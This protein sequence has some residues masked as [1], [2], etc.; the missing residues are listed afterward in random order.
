MAYFGGNRNDH[1][2]VYPGEIVYLSPS[3]MMQTYPVY[4]SHFRVRE[5]QGRLWLTVD[6]PDWGILLD[7]TP[8]SAVARSLVMIN[9]GQQLLRA[10]LAA[11]RLTTSGTWV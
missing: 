6:G 7:I 5:V 3:T 1:V 4:G 2:F 10:N 9:L 8:A 11:E